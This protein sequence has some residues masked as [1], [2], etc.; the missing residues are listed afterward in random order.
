MP[1]AWSN[2]MLSSSKAYIPMLD[3][4]GV[5]V[6]ICF[7]CMRACSLTFVARHDAIAIIGSSAIVQHTLC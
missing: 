3:A 1:G 4:G 5:N 6:N 7:L 2:S